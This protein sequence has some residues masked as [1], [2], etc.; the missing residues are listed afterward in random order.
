MDDFMILDTEACGERDIFFTQKGLICTNFANMAPTRGPNQ[1]YFTQIR[2]EAST[3]PEVMSPQDEPVNT[4]D[5]EPEALMDK[6]GDVQWDRLPKEVADACRALPAFQLRQFADDVAKGKQDEA[7]AILQASDDKQTLLT[8]LAKFTDYSGRTF[9]CTAY[10]YAYWAK[11]THM[12]RMLERH[13]DAETK[14][15]LLERVNEMEGTGLAYQ[16]H[17]VSYQNPHYDMSF[18]LKNLNLEEF[19][20]LQTMVGQNITKINNAT[21]DN[22][23]TL[24]FTATEYEQLKKELVPHK[25]VW[26][27]MLS[28]LGSFQCLSYLTYPAF[29]IASFFITSSAQSIGNKL[30]FDFKSLITALDTYVTNYDRWDYHHRDEAWLNVGKAQREVPAHIAHEYCR[31]DRSFDPR[32]EFNEE[33]LPRCFTFDNY[34]TNVKSW[35][36]LASSSSGLGFDFGLLRARAGRAVTS[37]PTPEWWLATPWAVV[38]AR[39]CSGRS[40]DLAAVSHLDEVRT[41][42]LTQSREILE[43][44]SPNHGLRLS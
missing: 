28:C 26:N 38:V 20:Q 24:A 4:V 40:V 25:S 3:H 32:P 31:G 10:E 33:T 34:V 2:E 21:A 42:D 35:F 27:W 16:Q 41:A 12:R 15:Q 44:A 30:Q 18:V 13:M 43:M 1:R 11:D 19:R 22:Y 23:A 36:P 39:G 8:R 9:N 29:F 6:L 7:E 37:R 5:I 17:G 14:T